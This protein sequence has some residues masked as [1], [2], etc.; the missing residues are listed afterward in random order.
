MDTTRPELAARLQEMADPDGWLPPWPQWWGD[1]EELAKLLPDPLVRH[2]FAAGCP[3]LPLTMLYESSPPAPG[4]PNAPGCFL[5]L[6]NS[7]EGEAARAR[8]LDWP[9]KQH[10]SNHLA[11][12]TEPGQVAES[13]R[14]LLTQLGLREPTPMKG[15]ASS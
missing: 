7:Y 4:W 5:Q 15:T 2:H 10:L 3:R 12:L 9:V 6:S 8:E 13:L 14:E 11:L 1:D